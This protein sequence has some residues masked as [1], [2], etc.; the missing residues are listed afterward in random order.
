MSDT[1]KIEVDGKTYEVPVVTGSEGERALDISK[2]R[3]E[4][5]YI[6][7]DP[8]YGSTGACESGV[9]FLNGE[10]GILR[11]RGYP[12]EQ[13]AEKAS[14]LEVAHLLIAGELPDR[15]KLA[16]FRQDITQHTL[17]HEDMRRFYDAFPPDAHPMAIISSVVCGLSTFYQDTYPIEREEQMYMT[18]IRLLAKLPTIQ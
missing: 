16:T 11:Y 17:I 13:L 12:I 6:T 1:A 18:T 10:K 2:F 9:T 15:D 5:G 3:A 8:G 7:L 14:F 4:T